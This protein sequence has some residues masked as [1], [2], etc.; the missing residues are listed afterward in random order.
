MAGMRVGTLNRL[1]GR[2]MMEIE[3]LKEAIDVVRVK[4]RAC[5]CRHGTVE[6]TVRNEGRCRHTRGRAWNLIERVA[7]PSN[8]GI[9]RAH[10]DPH[11]ALC[12]VGREIP[13]RSLASLGSQL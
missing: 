8:P 4:N 7:G 12:I 5:S 2:K 10:L 9:A 1:L 6:R 3:I 11:K 13:D